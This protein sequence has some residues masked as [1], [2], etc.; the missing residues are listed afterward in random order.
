METHRSRPEQT[1]QNCS[2]H[3]SQ[4]PHTSINRCRSNRVPLHLRFPCWD[5]SVTEQLQTITCGG[6]TPYSSCNYNYNL[7]C[8]NYN[9]VLEFKDAWHAVIWIT[10]NIATCIHNIWFVQIPTFTFFEV[11]PYCLQ[12]KAVMITGIQWQE[13]YIKLSPV[14]V[15]VRSKA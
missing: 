4:R 15:A 1:S 2:Q 13:K 10:R 6:V 5:T 7:Q 3:Q 12:R 14:P 8:P 11:L 9:S